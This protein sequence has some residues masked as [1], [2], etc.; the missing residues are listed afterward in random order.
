MTRR[1]SFA[2]GWTA[3]WVALAL[4][5]GGCA[6]FGEE[7]RRTE[8]AR[9]A[10]ACAPAVPEPKPD[11]DTDTPAL[12]G[13]PIIEEVHQS[14]TVA[15]SGE[16][17]TLFV[18]ARMPQAG[19]KEVPLVFLWFSFE[20]ALKKQSNTPHESRITWTAPPCRINGNI[21]V[22]VVSVMDGQGRTTEQ[23]FLVS[24]PPTCE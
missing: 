23:Q 11:T 22:I 5:S 7:L 17:I 10:S 18:K 16:E 15:N 8:C 13:P 9:D 24:G 21:H 6:D 19:P 1:D 12:D 14:A 3:A 20:G 4:T 2:P